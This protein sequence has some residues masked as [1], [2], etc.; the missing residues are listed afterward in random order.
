MAVDWSGEV[1]E[2][3]WMILTQRYVPPNGWGDSEIWPI[4]IE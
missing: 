1:V 4:P 3:W 2:A